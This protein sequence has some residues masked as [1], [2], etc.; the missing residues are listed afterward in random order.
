[1]ENNKLAELQKNN[2]VEITVKNML[3][4][5]SGMRMGSDVPVYEVTV[6]VSKITTGIQRG[7]SEGIP[8]VWEF[9]RTGND[10]ESCLNEAITAAYENN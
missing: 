9:V 10:Y 6:K 5:R 8:V 3:E 4:L 1:M 2:T 7:V